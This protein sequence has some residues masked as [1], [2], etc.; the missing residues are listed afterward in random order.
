MNVVE[1]RQG[2]LLSYN[3]L[4]ESIEAAIITDY[5]KRMVTPVIGYYVMFELVNGFRKELY[6]SKDRMIGHADHYSPAFSKK[7]YLDIL[8]GKIPAEDMWK[9]SSFWYKDFDEMAKKTMLRQIISRWGIMSIEMQSAFEADGSLR[10]IDQNGNIV[11]QAEDSVA[12]QIA[13][14]LNESSSAAQVVNLDEIE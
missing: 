9:Y 7:A 13:G 2:E 1:L 3:P 11:E 10:D 5:E 14:A 12:K 4:D 6:W 8:A